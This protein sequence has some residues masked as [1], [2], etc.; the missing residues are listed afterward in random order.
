MS[1]G[2]HL[3]HLAGAFALVVSGGCASGPPSVG[4]PAPVLS[5]YVREEE[6]QALLNRFSGRAEIYSGFDTQLFAGVT[7]QTWAFREARV[8]RLAWFRGM[9]ST[10]VEKLLEKERAEHEKYNVFVLGTWTTDSRY[11]D[12]DRSDSVWRIA[13]VV[14][15]EEILPE[16][17]ARVSRVTQDVR[18][19]YPYMGNFWVQYRARFP[20]FRPDGSPVIRPGT[21]KVKVVLASS[22]GRAEMSTS[23]EESS[24]KTTP[25][26]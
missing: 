9:T 23:A 22:L 16:D 12:F 3:L 5:D 6:Y 4:D 2:R 18:A 10:E 17:V 19:I 7:Y 13:L 1:W 20:R 25:L 14:D 8:R 24:D 15:G 21:K 11:D 26:R